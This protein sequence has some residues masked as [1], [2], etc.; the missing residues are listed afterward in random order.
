M[1]KV[2]S[3]APINDKYDLMGV[4]DEFCVRLK[5]E[6]PKEKL[7]SLLLR[8]KTKLFKETKIYILLSCDKFSCRNTLDMSVYFYETGYFEFSHPSFLVTL[9]FF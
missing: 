4:S 9:Q 3:G 5:E 6:I 8:T 7:D 1:D 2:I